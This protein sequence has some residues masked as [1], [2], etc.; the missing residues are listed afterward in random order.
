MTGLP[1]PFY[2]GL[3]S[4]RKL[5]D[6]EGLGLEYAQIGHRG[7]G[8]MIERLRLNEEIGFVGVL[9]PLRRG[10]HEPLAGAGGGHRH[11]VTVARIIGGKPG[12]GGSAGVSYLEST[13]GKRCFPELWSLRNRL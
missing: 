5:F 1:L 8:H 10:G 7:H 4:F 9:A 2:C 6:H 13:L 11:A 12:T 3:A